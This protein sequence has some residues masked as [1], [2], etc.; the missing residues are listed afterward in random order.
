MPQEFIQAIRWHL[1]ALTFF[2]AFPYEW[3]IEDSIL[4]TKFSK[5]WQLYSVLFLMAWMLYCVFYFIETLEFMKRYE[6][7][8][9]LKVAFSMFSI[10]RLFGCICI[11]VIGN[12]I[13]K[14][15]VV[16]R[17]FKQALQ[18]SRMLKEST[19]ISKFRKILVYKI[20]LYIIITLSWIYFYIRNPTLPKAEE[21]TIMF[22]CYHDVVLLF[23]VLDV[24]Y[25]FT[26]LIQQCLCE[27]FSIFCYET[28][29]HKAQ[30]LNSNTYTEFINKIKIN[31]CMKRYFKI[32]S[33]AKGMLNY[34]SWIFLLYLGICVSTLVLIAFCLTQTYHREEFFVFLSLGML[35]SLYIFLALEAMMLPILQV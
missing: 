1:K 25:T 34:Y 19:D 12:N 10:I 6:E 3:K 7:S 20:I 11:L 18:L 30:S 2:G 35:C 14:A 26:W 15:Y 8:P 17:L 27:C 29:S 13:R 4:K 24:V 28:E 33:F 21:I 23:E 16:K 32:Q 5:K 31:Q 9:T 22:D